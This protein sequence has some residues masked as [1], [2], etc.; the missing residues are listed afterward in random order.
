MRILTCFITLLFSLSFSA[1]SIS[2]HF[3]PIQNINNEK[4]DLK[5]TYNK[6]KSDIVLSDI[7]YTIERKIKLALVNNNNIEKVEFFITEFYNEAKEEHNPSASSSFS[8]RYLFRLH[9]IASSSNATKEY[10]RYYEIPTFS[11]NVKH[12]NRFD[13]FLE[14]IIRDF[15]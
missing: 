3:T 5:V 15:N 13:N 6:D 2:E 8:P 7:I 10:S 12:D 9:I 11:F 4:I 1:C 14:Q